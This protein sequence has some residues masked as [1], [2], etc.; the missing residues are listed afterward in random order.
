MKKIITI[1]AIAFFAISIVSCSK[2][3]SDF[4][5][6]GP[7]ETPPPSSPEV[8]VVSNWISPGSFFESSDRFNK[9]SITGVCPFTAA[10]QLKYN[11]STHVELVYAR[12]PRQRITYEYKKLAFGFGIEVNGS[13]SRIYLDYSLEPDG[14]KIYFKNA[15]YLSLLT[16]VD[17]SVSENWVYRYIVIPK[18]KYQT[19]N[20]DWNDLPA[21]A[22]A[23]GFSL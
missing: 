12:M 6:Q 16:A 19:T 3:S 21:V 18:T 1:I 15:D 2:T 11:E 9:L 10:T 17:Q 14:L 7:A 13:T 5:R 8:T 23:L 20:V 4:S 22:L